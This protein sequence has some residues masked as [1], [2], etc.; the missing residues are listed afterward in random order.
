M[1][2]RKPPSLLSFLFESRALLDV[3]SVPLTLAGSKLGRNQTNHALPIILFPGFGSDEIYLK[4][5]EHYLSNL[6]YQAEGWG[7][8]TNLA[9]ADID[10]TLEDLHPRWEFENPEGYTPE[11]YRGEGGVPMLC[12]K[13][14]DRVIKRSEELDSP[15]VLIGWSLGGYLARECA[16]E[17]PEQVAQIITFGAP[18]YGGPKYSRVASVFKARNFDLDWIEESIERRSN[19]PITQPI[20]SIYSKSDGIVS[21]T[22]AIDQESP[23]VKNIEVNASHL[24]MGFNRK[25][26]KII[27]DALQAEALQR[28][29]LTS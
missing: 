21:W 25:V 5:L 22:A 12:D 3:A 14:I 11:N 28:A 27:A 29:E 24:G 4:A 26:W 19:K 9:G 17:L 8:G 7:L 18:V 15:V 20:T 1:T 10:H 6:G 16:R 13:A 23:N 2:E